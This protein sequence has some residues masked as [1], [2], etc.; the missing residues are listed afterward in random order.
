MLLDKVRYGK[1]TH[2]REGF[3]WREHIPATETTK[4]T[5]LTQD[6]IAELLMRF[7]VPLDAQW[8]AFE[9]H[10]CR[11]DQ[12]IEVRIK[13][14]PSDVDGAYPVLTYGEGPD[15]CIEYTGLDR[16]LAP[17]A[18]RTVWLALLYGAFLPEPEETDA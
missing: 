6:S 15:D 11:G 8:L 2:R 5:V 17:W 9:L 1:S 18:G 13:L 4:P 7:G 10:D 3:C 14:D 16:F 12:R